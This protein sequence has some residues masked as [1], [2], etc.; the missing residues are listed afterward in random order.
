M[1]KGK[2]KARSGKNLFLRLKLVIPFILVD[3]LIVRII[4]LYL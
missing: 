3:L 4:S 2:G 1:E